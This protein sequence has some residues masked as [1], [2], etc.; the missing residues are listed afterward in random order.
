MEQLQCSASPGAVTSI[1][2]AG[3]M[4]NLTVFK[5]DSNALEVVTIDGKPWFN[6]SQVAKALGYSNPSKAVQDN[7]S[8]KYNQQLDLVSP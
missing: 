2:S 7:V 1:K 3:H 4:D 6:A 8:D 5:F